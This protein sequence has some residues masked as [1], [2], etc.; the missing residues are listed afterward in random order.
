MATEGPCN[1]F[2][3]H[4]VGPS[5]VIGDRARLSLAFKPSSVYAKLMPRQLTG[6]AVS[7]RRERVRR[8]DKLLVV[9]GPGF[10]GLGSD[11]GRLLRIFS[12]VAG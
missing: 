4:K 1:R 5:C 12:L 7:V 10:H 6:K 2:G 9:L 3:A 11:L 8:P